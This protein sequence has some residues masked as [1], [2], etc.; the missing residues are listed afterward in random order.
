M[1]MFQWDDKDDDSVHENVFGT[2]NILIKMFYVTIE[3]YTKTDCQVT[4]SQ[5]I[6]IMSWKKNPSYI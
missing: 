5:V 4:F 6:F 2:Y 1:R 3:S